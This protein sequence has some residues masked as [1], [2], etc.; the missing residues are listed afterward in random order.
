MLSD[1]ERKALFTWLEE[2]VDATFCPVFIVSAED[3][4]DI[5]RQLSENAKLQRLVETGRVKVFSKSALM[6]D[7][8]GYLETWVATNPALAA[9]NIWANEYE[10]ATNRLF[11]D[12]ELLEPSWPSYVW[13][14][15]TDDGIDP[16]YELAAVISANLLQ[17]IDVVRFDVEAINATATLNS[18]A[19]R[20]VTQGR[21]TL[22]GHRLYDSMVLPGDLFSGKDDEVWVNVTPACHTVLSR[23]VDESGT[24]SPETVPLHLVRGVPLPVPTSKSKFSTQKKDHDGPNGMLVHA[25]LGDQP[26]AFSFRNQKV[27][28]WGEVAANRIGRLLPPYITLLQQRNSAYL[29]NE[30]LP[31][32]EFGL[33]E[34]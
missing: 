11:Q 8:L 20:R 24:P 21:T 1:F 4:D 19:M 9:L 30:G 6:S 22:P 5:Q 23:H 15:A 18:A 2:F 13:Q 33:Y 14:A 10:L 25:M 32:V 27:V 7:F 16:S 29:M 34:A 26:Y 3:I 31:R 17:R 12:M 28:T